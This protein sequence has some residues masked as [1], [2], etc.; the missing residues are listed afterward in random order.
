MEVF[1]YPYDNIPTTEHRSLL[2]TLRLQLAVNVDYMYNPEPFFWSIGCL[3][4]GDHVLD[5]RAIG[6]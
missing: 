6:H 5:L 2:Y 1:S 4:L 3:F